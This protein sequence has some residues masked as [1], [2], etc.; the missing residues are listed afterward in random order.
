MDSQIVFYIY[1]FSGF[2]GEYVV[3]NKNANICSLCKVI[4]W[5]AVAKLNVNG[6]RTD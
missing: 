4:A 2:R 6:R 1:K 3:G 5:S